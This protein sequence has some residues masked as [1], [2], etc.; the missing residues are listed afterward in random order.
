MIAHRAQ[1]V[2]YL[3]SYPHK[4]GYKRTCLPS[5]TGT[6]ACMCPRKYS[7][8]LGCTILRVRKKQQVPNC[9]RNP[10]HNAGGSANRLIGHLSGELP[11]RSHKL[12]VISQLFNRRFTTRDPR[13]G[14]DARNHLLSSSTL[15]PFSFARYPESLGLGPLDGSRTP[16]LEGVSRHTR[17]SM[18]QCR[19][20]RLYAVDCSLWPL[21]R[22]I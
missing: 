17:R 21:F 8:L 1:R 18:V 20:P 13:G 2:R 15:Y 11:P 12:T 7:R 9:G 19:C 16:T 10:L 5:S 4:I 3:P 14:S 6:H 22:W